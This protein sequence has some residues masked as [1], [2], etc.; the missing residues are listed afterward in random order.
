MFPLGLALGNPYGRTG[1]F[2]STSRKNNEEK[3]QGFIQ[4]LFS[5]PI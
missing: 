2:L 1:M 5:T 3:K 4:A